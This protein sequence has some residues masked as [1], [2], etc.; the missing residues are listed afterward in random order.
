MSRIRRGQIKPNKT[1]VMTHRMIALVANDGRTWTVA[2]VDEDV[3]IKG[4][5]VFNPAHL[6]RN[7]AIGTTVNLASKELTIL[8]AGLTELRRGMLRRA[9]T[10]GDKDAGIL[11][12]RLGV[13]RDDTV[14][15]AGLGSAGLGLHIARALGPSGHHITVEP[16]E[17]H[18]HV[19]LD[20]LNRA[21]LA[22]VDG[23]RHSTSQEGP[24][25]QQRRCRASHQRALMPL[26]WTWPTTRLPSRRWHRC[27][28]LEGGWRVIA[29]SP[30]SSSALGRHARPQDWKWIGL[31]KSWS[32][33]G[34]VPLEEVYVQ[35]TG[36]LATRPSCSSRSDDRLR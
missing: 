5:G 23:P 24:K 34:A 9:Q 35:Q 10:I 13:G 19:G 7:H 26:C 14:L 4:L 12:A 36:L 21:S 25:P 11:V 30:V 27:C 28:A 29:P 8:P 3:K 1:V 32:G 20:N 16:R 22:W 17:E 31:E 15:E 6:L 2:V 18:A 33:R